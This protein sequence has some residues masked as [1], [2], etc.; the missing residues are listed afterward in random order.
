MRSSRRLARAGWGRSGRP[1]TRDSIALSPSRLPW[2]NSAT[3]LWGK[4]LVGLGA[5]TGT[6]RERG[7]VKWGV[8]DAI[9]ISATAASAVQPE[10]TTEEQVIW[11]GMPAPGRLFHQADLWLVPFSLLWGGFTLYWEAGV[12]GLWGASAGRP[13]YFAVF[14]GLPFV[15]MGQYLIWGRFIY[16]AWK[17]RRTFYAVTNRRVIVVQS[18]PARKVAS[19]YID[20]LPVLVKEDVS[21]TIGTLRFAPELP[22]SQGRGLAGWDSMA[23]GTVPAF[24]DVEDVDGVYR[25]V[26]RLREQAA[27]SQG[28]MVV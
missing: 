28:K 26:S 21:G 18:G 24:V 22:G 23:V 7:G 14:W 20:S 8:P 1:V 10:M 5:S 9:P 25:L 15:L 11:A 3:V 27:G 16:A 2:L 4:F 19:A 13:G 12:L 6:E 17:K